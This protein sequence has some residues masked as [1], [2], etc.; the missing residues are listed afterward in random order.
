[1]DQIVRATPQQNSAV[2]APFLTK[3]SAIQAGVTGLKQTLNQYSLQ[4]INGIQQC[5]KISTFNRTD[6]RLSIGWL[7]NSEREGVD[8]LTGHS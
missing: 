5:P 6:I 1:V 3:L 8:Y 4:I 2:Y 7:E